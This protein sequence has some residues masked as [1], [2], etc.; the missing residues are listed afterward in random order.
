MQPLRFFMNSTF[1]NLGGRRPCIFGPFYPEAV[2][3]ILG[4]HTYWDLILSLGDL[5]GL[6]SL[7][8]E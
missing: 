2:F 5:E 8:R 3:P 4:I 1:F 7:N 6:T